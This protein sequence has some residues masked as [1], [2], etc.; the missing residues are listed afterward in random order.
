MS[1]FVL[2]TMVIL[3]AFAWVI[4]MVTD[5]DDFGGLS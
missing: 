4:V 3:I 5:D 2:T 1:A